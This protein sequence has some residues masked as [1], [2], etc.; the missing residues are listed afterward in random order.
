MGKARSFDCEIN[1][2]TT[3]TAMHGKRHNHQE[4][5]NKQQWPGRNHK[6]SPCVYSG[7]KQAS[8][9][10]QYIPNGNFNDTNST[11]T[12]NGENWQ[13]TLNSFCHTFSEYINSRKEIDTIQAN[14]RAILEEWRLLAAILDR[15][16]LITYFVVILVSLGLLFPR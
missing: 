8:F 9:F 11:V 2:M 10:S 15:I 6:P 12:S 14:N 5:N 7:L 13:A 4:L 3:S 1:E 16:F